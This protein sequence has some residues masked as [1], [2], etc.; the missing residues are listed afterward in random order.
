MVVAAKKGMEKKLTRK[1]LPNGFKFD[2][3]M[4]CQFIMSSSCSTHLSTPPVDIVAVVAR[5]LVGGQEVN[6]GQQGRGTTLWEQMAWQERHTA[7]NVTEA[8]G[9]GQ[10]GGLMM[11]EQH[12]ADNV[13][14]AGGGG[15]LGGQTMLW[16]WM[17]WQEQHMADNVTRVDGGRWDGGTQQWSCW[18]MTCFSSHHFSF[19]S[20]S[21]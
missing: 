20:L 15:W 8:D 13:V 2:P 6:V 12:T 10:Q 9:S 16:E 14:R 1:S 18:L 19:F 5:A 21:I 17:A 4:V 3:K 11:Q 7:D